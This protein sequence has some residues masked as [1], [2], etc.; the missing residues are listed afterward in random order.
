MW[1]TCKRILW[2]WRGVWLTT[3]SIAVVVILLRF[4][5]ILEPLEWS[6]YDQYMRW[7]SL[8]PSDQRI[9][10]VGLEEA[11]MKY[12][13]QGYVP[14]GVYAEL[15]RKL[16]AMEPRAIGLDIYRDLPYEPG[17]DQLVQIFESTPNLIGVEKVIGDELRE[18]VAPP[19]VL[20]QKG[21]TGANDFILDKDNT[22]RRMLLTQKT[23]TGETFYSFGLY[24]A[25]LY[26]K[27]EGIS[28]QIV[29]GTDN[30]WQLGNI[31]FFPFE[32]NDGGYV[33][34]D[35]GG[36]QVFLNY[37]GSNQHIEIV[38]FRDILE[39]KVPKDWGRDRI[40]L[41]GAVGESFQD[42]F[43]TPYTQ[44]ANQRMSGVEIHANIT[45]QIISAA[46]E[47]RPLIR[48]AP[49]WLEW[50]W[51]LLGSGVGATL[52]WTLRSAT[53]VKRFLLRETGFFIFATGGLLGSTYFAFLNGWWLPIIPPLLA[54]SGSAIVIISF[55]ARSAAGIRKT[56]GRYLSD[57][58]VATLLESPDGLQMGGERRKITILTSDLRGFTALS[59]RLSPEEVVKILNF[60]L[61]YMA[62]VITAYQGTIDEFMGDGIL[63][64]F[65]APT[66][67]HDDAKRAVACA[68]AM[69]LEMI[70]VNQQMKG[71]G[72]N[73]L[74]M[75]IGI[76]T[77]EVVVGN[78]GSEKR[79]KYGVVGSQVN[80]TY[81]IESYTTGG[82]II[83]SEP[84]LK[85]AGEQQIKIENQKLVQP[86]GVQQPICIYEISGISGDYQL[87]MPKEE[88]LFYLVPDDIPLFYTILEGKHVGENLFSGHLVELSAKGG[89]IL[90]EFGDKSL[91]I[92]LTNIKIN[93]KSEDS[94]LQEDIY[95]KVLEKPASQNKFY[96]RFTSKPPAIEAKLDTIY[97][98]ILK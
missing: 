40:I 60:Y 81:R 91:P 18:R 73:P 27:T 61:S 24:L 69:Q 33:R 89:L 62:D 5:G 76:N 54:L 85:E 64:L 95:A 93:L 21:Q 14:D 82:Q 37:R 52:T 13:G 36:Y 1:A 47:N 66:Q 88:E 6:V 67:R 75:G 17:H 53:N 57:E 51:I 56:F 20:K 34:A 11:D 79:T 65:G 15:L 12:I 92:V 16:I 30:W 28:V 49:K 90:S 97:K 41:I 43:A 70:K 26:L 4:S 3:P 72:L 71:W 48:T 59:E 46:L 58:I 42:L 7:R 50:L 10:I 23:K 98:S 22:I 39:D 86:K 77:G 38:P 19:P 25:L 96:I 8:E 55:V 87:F 45:S 9:V 63:V 32:K 68:V 44:S 74:E 35:A 80:L 78:L 83:I 84:T 29:E 31:V 2:N 94:E